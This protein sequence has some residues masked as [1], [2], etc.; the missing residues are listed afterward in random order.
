MPD[1]FVQDWTGVTKNQF[2]ELCNLLNYAINIPSRTCLS[3]LLVKYRKTISDQAIA[4]F[5]DKR[6]ENKCRTTDECHSHQSV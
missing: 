4:D 1:R 2:I 5:S 3:C 6:F